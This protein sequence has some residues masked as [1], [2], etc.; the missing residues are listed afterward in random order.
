MRCPH[1]GGE[2]LTA[3]RVE[4]VLNVSKKLGGRIVREAAA[5][6]A[7]RR[8]R[9]LNVDRERALERSKPW[10]AEGLSRATWY[11]RKREGK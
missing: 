4:E 11:R 3:E 2:F 8:G 10:L 5:R 7:P 1:C 6:E 9:P